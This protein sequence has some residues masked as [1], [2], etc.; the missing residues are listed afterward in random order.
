[1]FIA[2]KIPVGNRMAGCAGLEPGLALKQANVS[3]SVAGASTIAKDMAD[4]VLMDGHLHAM[5]D[6]HEISTSLDEKLKRSLKFCIAPGVVNLLGAFVF[7]FDTL[8]SLLVNSAFAAGGAISVSSTP[9]VTK[10]KSA[11]SEVADL[12]LKNDNDVAAP[13]HT[14]H[15][16]PLEIKQKK[17]VP[18][19]PAK[20]VVSMARTG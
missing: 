20:P 8:A 2:K 4:I 3:I 5:N 17:A 12:A 15:P 1:M 19:V 18:P 11:S 9:D 13:G 14:L 16:T 7:K 10:K 6:L